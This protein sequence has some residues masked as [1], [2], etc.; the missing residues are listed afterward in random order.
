MNHHSLLLPSIL[1][2]R[3]FCFCF[4][5]CCRCCCCCF[6]LLYQP[7]PILIMMYFWLSLSFVYILC[8]LSLS[9]S[10]FSHWYSYVLVQ[11][12]GAAMEEQKGE[13][14]ELE[15]LVESI[16]FIIFVTYNLAHI[17]PCSLF[18]MERLY[19]S[20]VFLEKKKMPTDFFS[21]VPNSNMY[22]VSD[23]L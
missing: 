23:R 15:K 10:L 7:T 6:C 13:R 14:E 1:S 11:R 20:L 18:P 8:S 12:H 4:C 2:S 19:E 3:W 17:Q 5:C 9:L 16:D 21:K 22:F